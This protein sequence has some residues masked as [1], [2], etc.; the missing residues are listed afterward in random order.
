[1]RK[2][3]YIILFAVIFSSCVKDKNS[4][5]ELKFNSLNIEGFYLIDN[6]LAFKDQQTFESAIQQL[7]N[8]STLELIKWNESIGFNSYLTAYKHSDNWS[9]KLEDDLFA[10]LINPEA[11]IVVENHLFKVD[12]KNEQT[13]EMVIDSFNEHAFSNAKK[14]ISSFNI[15][16]WNQNAFE[17]DK[18]IKG[19]ERWWWDDGYCRE[20]K[21]K[22]KDWE[23]A[24]GFPG[25]ETRFKAK[26]CFQRFTVYNSII[27]KFKADEK[28]LDAPRFAAH[29]ITEGENFFINN[30]GYKKFERENSGVFV[31]PGSEISHRP[32][33][34]TLRLKEYYVSV[35]FDFETLSFHPAFPPR[36][37]TTLTI[38][39]N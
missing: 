16:S 28:G 6:T 21:E 33:Q 39:C 10:C 17:K 13:L 38:Q 20:N 8:H 29:Y 3:I 36:D 1:M 37:E 22:D 7:A 12:F 34:S 27:I 24:V 15:L 18:I 26:V 25:L 19:N 35:K 9:E 30:D 31:G 5:S 23:F 4:V 14:S 11:E 2:I 32:Y